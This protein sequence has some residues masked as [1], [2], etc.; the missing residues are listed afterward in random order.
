MS[1]SSRIFYRALAVSAALHGAALGLIPGRVHP[2]LPE[3][4]SLLAHLRP[5]ASPPRPHSVPPSPQSSVPSPSTR[6]RRTVRPPEPLYRPLQK[7]ARPS[8]EPKTNPPPVAAENPTPASKPDPMAAPA[9]IGP[10]SPTAMR[11]NLPE[12]RVPPQVSAPEFSA[13]YL[14]NPKPRY[15]LSARRREESGTVRLKVLVTPQGTAARVE[16]EQSSGSSALDQAAL[17]T[18]KDWRFLPARR[19]DESIEAWVKVPVRFRLE[20]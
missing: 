13:A 12:T 4:M 2:P 14:H 19:G 17:E 20:E 11:E 9:N 1:S 6:D 5:F 7:Q 3:P 16:L 15:P 18:V 10:P 8:P